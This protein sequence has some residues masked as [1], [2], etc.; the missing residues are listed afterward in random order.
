M[1][2]TKEVERLTCVLFVVVLFLVSSIATVCG[3]YIQDNAA[4]SVQNIQYCPSLQRY[5]SPG[6]EHEH[7]HTVWDV[8]YRRAL[9]AFR[10][11]TD[12]QKNIILVGNGG[13]GVIE[14][15]YG[16][17]VKYGANGKIK[18]NDE[19]FAL[20]I[21]GM[22]GSVSQASII[23][24]SVSQTHIMSNSVFQ[25]TKT[26]SMKQSYEA[27]KTMVVETPLIDYKTLPIKKS[28]GGTNL[29]ITDV[30]RYLEPM[31]PSTQSYWGKWVRFYDVAVD[32]NDNIIVVGEIQH[33]NTE[34][35]RNIYV[36]KYDPDGNV[37][38][39]RVYKR[40]LLTPRDL[41]TGVAI[42]SNDN[43]FVSIRSQEKDSN[44]YKGWILKLSP[45][46][47]L[48]IKES[49]HP[50]KSIIFY[51]VATDSNDNV[52]VAGYIP[53]SGVMKVVKYSNDLALLDEWSILIR[54][55]EPQAINVDPNN[56]VIV[57][58]SI[59][60]YKKEKQYLVK[61]SSDGTILW[62]NKSTELGIWYDV[63]ALGPNV[64]AVA[65]INGGNETIGRFYVGLYNENGIEFKRF[66]GGKL[67]NLQMFFSYGLDVDN[68]G[69]IVVA[70]LRWY[71][72]YQFYMHA[73]KFY[74]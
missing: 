25:S 1:I 62:S 20:I 43:I 19:R 10:V 7:G 51:D 34:D 47:G 17:V 74:Q 28:F 24:G 50:D 59:G 69:D 55:I 53:T 38:W 15:P 72:K 49:I 46:L 33:R 26:V 18:W 11:A 58:G 71:G 52:F 4:V 70:G 8:E 3:Q 63:V 41:C 5:V 37:L 14:L 64:T 48:K 54:P 40:Y 35:I 68:N 73:M 29:D 6:S 66:L 2:K 23:S 32:S 13:G 30:H 65:G 9:I 60:F 12:S 45:N 27:C 22:P 31:F 56:N 61:F 16:V 21:P 67:T 57:A 36:V 44:D 39:D 42:D